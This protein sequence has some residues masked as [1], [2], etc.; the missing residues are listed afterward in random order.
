MPCRDVFIPGSRRP[1]G[2]FRKPIRVKE[3]YVP[4]DEM[5]LYESKGRQFNRGRVDHPI[6]LAPDDVARHRA[7]REAAERA[8]RFPSAA[9]DAVIPGL[10]APAKSAK[11]SKSKKK[12]EKKEPP[13][14]VIDESLV[15]QLSKASIAAAP[16][17][18]LPEAEAAELRSKLKNLKKKLKDVVQLAEKVKSGQVTPDPEQKAKILRKQTLID[19]IKS[20]ERELGK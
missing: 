9:G 15:E 17:L 2:T 5:P 4:Q 11:K 6:G 1:D 13:A 19:D 20:I 8:D 3:G 16:E 7:G 10:A 18:P 14:P 12:P